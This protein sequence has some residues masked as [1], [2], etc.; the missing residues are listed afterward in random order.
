MDT[1]LK[2]LLRSNFLPFARK[3]LR[4]LDGVRLG[5]EA[6]L[7]YLAR[8]LDLFA[9]GDTYRVIINLPPGHLKTSL[10][11]VC[12]AAWLLGQ[13]PSLKLMV[14]SHA[15][16]LSKSIARKIRSL[17]QSP[18]FK[19]LFKTRITKGHA[20]VTDF[21]TASGGGV[22][23]TSFQAGFTGRRADVIIVDDPHDITDDIEQIEATIEKF[24][25]VL[26][27]R[28]NDRKNGRVLVIAHRVNERD[29]SAHLIGRRNWK[30][31]TL[32][33]IAINDQTFQTSK[34]QWHRRRGELLRPGSFSPED[35][36]EL[37]ASSFNPDFGMLYQ[38]DIESQGLP[39]FR[40]DHF[41]TFPDTGLMPGPIV[42]SVDAA[43]SSRPGSAFSVIQV[44]R[45]AGDCY[46]LLDQFRERID[47][48]GLR[49]EVR[50]FRRRYRP[51][52]IL[53]ERAANGH[54]LISDLIRRYGHI[55]RPIDPHGRSKTAR[56]IAHADT[57]LSRRVYLPA[58]A[59][60][61]EEFVREFC[62]FPKGKFSD[63]VDA[64][65]QLL[66]HASEFA[67]MAF[68]SGERAIAAT[69]TG[70]TVTFNPRGERGSVGVA[71]Y[72]RPAGPASAQGP[73]ISIKTEV[74]Y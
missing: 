31:V 52:A 51:V 68:A 32:P 14:V 73:I 5:D 6:Y 54:A 71:R 45:L 36:D 22:F 35:L 25:T 4:E 11:S 34:G 30:H 56:L 26:L 47:F 19:A 58:H 44:W 65:T 10:G 21:G 1:V 57:I 15:E 27:S 8:E 39:A 7:K 72:G 43:M 16:H 66:D 2:A 29:L 42:L 69:G 64:A 37:R 55:V 13:D 18:L 41:P 40:G 28:L 63:Q 70:R 12:L 24:N 62:E 9:K 33:L 49:D 60:W 48:T 50:Y 38:Q 3:A 23:V 67:G 74:K 46:F 59:A 17:L 61:R 20:E 53:I